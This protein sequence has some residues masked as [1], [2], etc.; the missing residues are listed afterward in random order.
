MTADGPGE[1]LRHP[2]SGSHSGVGGRQLP[3]GPDD[4]ATAV[5]DRAAGGPGAGDLCP[6][7]AV[8]AAREPGTRGGAV[9]GS[10]APAGYVDRAELAQAVSTLTAKGG[11]L[12]APATGLFGAGGFGKTTLAV[13]ACHHRAVRRR[14]GSGVWVTLGRDLDDAGLAARISG[15]VRGLGGAFP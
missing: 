1:A 10:A 5:V 4:P 11:A 13:R 6:G 8:D 9:A 15:I 7:V 12:V 2:G 3:A 14:F